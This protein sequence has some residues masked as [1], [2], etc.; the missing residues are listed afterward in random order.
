MKCRVNFFLTLKN[1]CNGEKKT[2]VIC[3][4]VMK[5]VSY[6]ITISGS[7]DRVTN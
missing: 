5:P 1:I 4:F 3:D 7:T 2:S 6:E